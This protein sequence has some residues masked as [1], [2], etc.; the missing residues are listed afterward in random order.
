M[1][2]FILVS[3]ATIYSHL[4][5]TIKDFPIRTLVSGIEKVVVNHEEYCLFSLM[6]ELR[7]ASGWSG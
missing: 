5:R 4:T 3:R 1:T 6:L 2:S 7:G